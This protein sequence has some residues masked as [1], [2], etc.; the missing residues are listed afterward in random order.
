MDGL[1]PALA[2]TFWLDAKNFTGLTRPWF[3]NRLGMPLSFYYPGL[4]RT[5]ALELVQTSTGIDELV[6]PEA[7]FDLNYLESEVMKKA[8]EALDI[9]STRLG[10]K[11]FLMG[12]TPT[13]LDAQV[14][15]HLAPILKVPVP[16]RNPLQRSIL[17]RPNLVHFV[18]RIST[19]Y[20][21]KFCLS[22]ERNRSDE[23]SKETPSEGAGDEPEYS[24][25]SKVS[26]V[27]VGALAMVGYG[28]LTGIFA[29]FGLTL[30]SAREAIGYDQY[31][32]EGED[33]D[34]EDE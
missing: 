30:D 6:D 34:D 14:Y 24:T 10:D 28:M 27:L 32:G 11:P 25:L 3:A 5:R 33:E 4:Y 26:A 2:L 9:I 18:T 12:K 22:E 19:T 29:K 8:N 15:A 13:S 21:A 31:G 1:S 16:S 20:F 7:D 23:G 17:E